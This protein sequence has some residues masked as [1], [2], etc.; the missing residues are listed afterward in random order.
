MGADAANV[1]PPVEQCF[2]P[3]GLDGERY[4]RAAPQLDALRNQIDQN[5]FPRLCSGVETGHLRCIE[6]DREHA[7][8]EIIRPKNLAESGCDNHPYAQIG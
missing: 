2:A 1:V 3:R 4:K 6:H 7:V 5:R 8:L